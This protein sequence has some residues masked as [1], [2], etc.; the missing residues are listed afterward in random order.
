MIQPALCLRLHSAA[1][2]PLAFRRLFACRSLALK[3][4]THVQDSLTHSWI[5][6]PEPRPWSM[7]RVSFSQACGYP[8]PHSCCSEL[9]WTAPAPPRGQLSKRAAERWV[10][11]LRHIR[12]LNFRRVGPASLSSSTQPKEG[13]G[14]N[15]P[16][17]SLSLW[18]RQGGWGLHVLRHEKDKK[19][20]CPAHL[21][22]LLQL[23]HI[24]RHF[25]IRKDLLPAST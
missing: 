17:A 21:A 4:K 15:S 9:S 8:F 22:F 25:A 20:A 13:S 5:L 18:P 24:Q 10:E 6:P 16:C 1:M 19:Q 3:R 14:C 2:M 11:G 23:S 7:Q 12:L